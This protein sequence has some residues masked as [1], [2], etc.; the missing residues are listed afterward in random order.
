MKVMDR[1]KK[2]VLLAVLLLLLVP[3]GLTRAYFS[4]YEEQIG[5]ARIN[6]KGETVIEEEVQEME[7]TIT[8]V[9]TG[10][11]GKSA[12]VVVRVRIFGPD[13]M[14]VPTVGDGWVLSGDWYYYKHVLAPGEETTSIT[15]SVKD[16]PVTL[17]LSDMDIIVVQE[18]APAVYDVNNVVIAPEGWAADEFP[19][20]HAE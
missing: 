15:A 12:S 16:V 10:E 17:E 7:K 1:N 20:I 14:T 19:E 8:I 2:L 9:N 5:E 13:E 4:D 6:L 11:P 18:S 3:L